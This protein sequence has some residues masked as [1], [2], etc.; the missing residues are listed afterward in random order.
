MIRA[1]TAAAFGLAL[2]VGLATAAA[3][4]PARAD[5]PARTRIGDPLPDLTLP[6]VGGGRLRLRDLAGRVVAVSFYSSSC[7]PCKKELPALLRAAARVSAEAPVARLT[8]LVIAVDDP[9]GDP[10]VKQAAAATWLVDEDD[11]A[12]AAFEP[13]TLPCTYLADPR[14]VVRHINRGFGAGYEAR[15]EKWLRALVRDRTRE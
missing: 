14:L 15:V 9:A 5:P 10:M 12:R 11:R 8:V 13:R 7:E 2:T 3:P 1:R 4:R 6:K